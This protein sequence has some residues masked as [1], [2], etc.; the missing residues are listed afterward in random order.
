M[1][2]GTAETID[3]IEEP[4]KKRSGFSGGSNS[5]SGGG[6]KGGGNGPN[7][8]DEDV[9]D[10]STEV[11]SPAKSRILTTFLLLVV[12]MT[13]GGLIAAYVVIGTNKAQEWQP[14]D[15]SDLPKPLWISTLIILLSSISYFISERAA[16]TRDQLKAKKWLIVTTFLG[17]VF[18]ASQ[19]LSWLELTRRGLYMYGNPYVGFFYV[20]TAVHAVHV[21]GG[22][23]ALS[24]IL[25]KSWLPARSKNELLK[26]ASLANVVGWYW[27]FM[28][29]LWIVL[30][31]LL[32]FSK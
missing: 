1:E 14:F 4:L 13:F 18:I 2:T 25:L 28:G 9:S 21:I 3:E 19:L 26:R 30:F 29:V 6:N 16:I 11:F 12:L 27:H 17:S 7:S 22:I 10:D 32:G 5:G 8:N 24:T 20:L 31:L 15:L 23:V